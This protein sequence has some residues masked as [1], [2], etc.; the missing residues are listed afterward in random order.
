[1]ISNIYFTETYK[2]ELEFT[3]PHKLLIHGVHGAGYRSNHN[4]NASC[5][6]NNKHRALSY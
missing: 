1:M 6:N 5:K 4:P 3:K 2:Y